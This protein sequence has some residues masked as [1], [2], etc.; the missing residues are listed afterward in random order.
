[1]EQFQ[2]QQTRLPRRK[3]KEPNKRKVIVL[4]DD[5]TTFDFVTRM[6]VQIFFMEED[7]ARRTTNAI[8]QNGSAVVGV[9]PVDI[10]KSKAEAGMAMARAENFPLRITTEDV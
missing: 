7:E 2:K 8:D 1:M 4:N 5:V 6:L 3:T 10:A 9:Y